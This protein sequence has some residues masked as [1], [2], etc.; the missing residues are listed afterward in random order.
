MANS[1]VTRVLLKSTGV[2]LFGLLT[3]MYCGVQVAMEYER[4]CAQVAAKE[5]KNM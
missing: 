3:F 2:E 4:R 1:F 5:K